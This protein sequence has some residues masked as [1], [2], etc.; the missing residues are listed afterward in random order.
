[1]CGIAGCYQQADG[2]KLVDVMSDQIA[3]RGPDAAGVWSHE[4]DRVSIQLGHRRLSIIDLTAAAD[5]PLSKHGLTLVYNGELYNYKELRA[6]LVGRGTRFVTKSDT[7]VVL[8]ALRAWGPEALPRFRGM[9]AFA[10]A[11]TTTGELLLAR[12]PLGI[13]PLYYL[14]RGAGMLFAS[15]LKALL[16]AVGS[17]LRIEPGALVASM[18]YYWVPEQRCAIQGVQKL[19]AGSWARFRPDG[20]RE[21]HSYWRVEDVAL[22]AAAGPAADL[23]SVIEESVAAHLVADVPVSSFLSGGLDSSIITVLAHQAANGVDAYTITFRPEDQKLEAMPDDAVYARKVAA[24][25]GIKLHEI[26]ISPDIVSLLPRMVGILDEPIGDPAAINTLLMC[27][28]ARARGVKVILSGMGADELFGGYRK[29]LACL[30]ASRYGRLPGAVKAGARFAVDRVPV[31]IGDRGLRYSRWA[32]RF[33]TFADLPEE[34]RFRRS[35]TLY[36]PEDLAAL[37]GQDLESQVAHVVEEH[38]A[39][40][41]DNQLDDE[42]NR[43]CLA[44]SRL[45]MAGLNLTY[46]DRASMA[47]SVEVRVPFV[48]LIVA[49]AA[50]SVP[51]EEKI[52]GRKQKAALKDAAENWLPAEIVHRPKASFGAPLRAW[53][54]NDLRE[55]VSD[56]L[57]AGEL[58]QAG[59]LRRQALQRLIADDQAG[60]QDNAKQIWQ[61]LSMELWYRNV[62]SMGVAS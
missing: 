61:L 42:V 6:E 34:A 24:R 39:I 52:R 1:V 18:L 12:D 57:V 55:L 60:R 7:E 20:T 49:Q 48:D 56:V 37:V 16:A 59:V 43:M 27:E 3:H 11:D 62:R 54:R 36:D 5:Q 58:V 21:M 33:M 23:R 38:R 9:F 14:P 30:M 46:T 26:E 10:L 47:A 31:S 32:K 44:D 8:E 41:D 29:H 50:F 19:P 28:A 2:R 15:E 40:Y 35:Y 25:F 4:D 17:E 53:V 22:E 13:K 51:G 45:F